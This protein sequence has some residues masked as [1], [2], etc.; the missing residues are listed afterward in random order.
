YLLETSDGSFFI[1][2][3]FQDFVGAPTGIN[4]E[5]LRQWVVHPD[6]LD[7]LAASQRETSGEFRHELRIR[8]ADGE[9]VWF[10]NKGRIVHGQNGEIERLFGVAINIHGLKAA[11]EAAR[12]AKERLEA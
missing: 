9:Y 8:R 3:S 12:A 1:N 6:D 5:A 2:R 10:S 7:M 4:C 11:E